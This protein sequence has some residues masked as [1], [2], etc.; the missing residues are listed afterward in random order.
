M[1]Q[2]GTIIMFIGAV[3]PVEPVIVPPVIPGIPIPGIPIR[4]IIIGPLIGLSF[5]MNSSLRR[6]HP[7][8]LSH[9]PIIPPLTRLSSTFTRKISKFDDQ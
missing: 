4:S 2:R 9:C 1:V 6:P 8:G 7:Q 5:R 3:I